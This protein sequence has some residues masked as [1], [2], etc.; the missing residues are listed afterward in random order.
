[1]DKAKNLRDEIKTIEYI[2]Y[3]QV[4]SISDA[5]VMGFA[6]IDISGSW[7]LLYFTPGSASFTENTTNIN[8]VPLTEQKLS[9]V[10]PG[11]DDETPYEISGII[12]KPV[13]IRITYYSGKQKLVGNILSP[14]ILSTAESENS[15]KIECIRKS[16]E[17][18]KWVHTP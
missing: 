10:Y 13:I 17:K 1:M 12:R 16:I 3:D 15:Y 8:G 14:A 7:N 18:A 6:S 5:V 11:S 9:L 2:F 4:N